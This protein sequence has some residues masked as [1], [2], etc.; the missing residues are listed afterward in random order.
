MI[1]LFRDLLREEFY[2]RAALS[3]TN[4]WTGVA[5]GELLIK[6]VRFSMV[7]L[8]GGNPVNSTVR[9]LFNFLK[10]L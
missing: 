5:A 1:E 7:A 3:S 6:R 10:R 2:L 8:T 4:R 9:W